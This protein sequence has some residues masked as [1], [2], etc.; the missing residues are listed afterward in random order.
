MF[1]HVPSTSAGTLAA[2]IPAPVIPVNST[3]TGTLAAG[4]PAS[5][6]PVNSTSAGTLAA[7]IPAPLIPVRRKL[8][9]KKAGPSKEVNNS[10]FKAALE[11]ISNL[12]D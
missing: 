1:N 10:Q 5:V 7:G 8:P 6:I 9:A 3:S 2:G 4:I 12:E 11:S